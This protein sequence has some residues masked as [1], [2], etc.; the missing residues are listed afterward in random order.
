MPFSSVQ[1]QYTL[2]SQITSYFPFFVSR[3]LQ[4]PLPKY[5]WLNPGY[6][7]VAFTVQ[8]IKPT[9]LREF[10]EFEDRVNQDVRKNIIVCVFSGFLGL[11]IALSILA[12]VSRVL[13]Q[14][15]EWITKVARKIIHNND[16]ATSDR[17]TLR[18]TNHRCSHG[19]KKT[20]KKKRHL[21]MNQGMSTTSM[22]YCSDEIIVDGTSD[23]ENVAGFNDHH[24]FGY[25]NDIID[26]SSNGGDEK[27]DDDE[28]EKVDSFVNFDYYPSLDKE[29]SKR[30]C[31]PSTELQQL[32]E[33]FH[34][35]IHEFS[36]DGVSEVAEAGFCEIKNTM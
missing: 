6:I 22:K 15:L 23:A 1:L 14:P 2:S 26:C 13:T 25:N 35:M 21:T 7:P 33:S 36:G 3:L 16:T 10:H 12:C 9:V 28:E 20:K 34:S 8:K 29:D 19:K 31:T 30:R 27:D 17:G 4:P 18:N 5:P 11:I 24:D 32:L